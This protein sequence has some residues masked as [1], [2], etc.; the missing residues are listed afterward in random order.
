MVDDLVFPIEGYG[1]YIKK[2]RNNFI[3]YDED[4]ATS[5]LFGKRQLPTKSL[6]KDIQDITSAP[7]RVIRR[8]LAIIMEQLDQAH[9]LAK[10]PKRKEPEVFSE[11]IMAKAE[12]VLELD[13]LQYIV[14]TTHLLHAGDTELLKIEYVSALSSKLSKT[15][16]NLWPIGGSGKGKTHSM[17]TVI[18]LLPRDLYEVFT[19]ASPLSLF[20]Y[21]KRYGPSALDAILL[22]IDEVEAAKNALPMLRSL[23]GQTEITPRHLS[24]Y[25]AELLNLKIKG[26]RPIWFTSVKTFG[27]DQIKNRFINLNPDETENQDARV[28]E[29]QDRLFR[30]EESLDLEAFKIAQA[31]TSIIIKETDG[32]KVVI[33]FQIKWAYKERR[34][35]Y[36]VFLAFIRVI[37]KIH[38]K[39]RRRGA[40]GNIIAS[41]EDFEL[42]KNLW[43]ALEK[44]IRYRVTKSALS[45][46]DELSDNKSDAQTHAELTEKLPLGTRQIERLCEELLNEGLVNRAKRDVT[47]GRPAWE[48]WKATLPTIEDVDVVTG[49]MVLELIRNE[50]NGSSTLETDVENV[51]K[52]KNTLLR[53]TPYLGDG[54]CE[55]CE[56]KPMEWKAT[57]VDGENAV[58]GCA[59]CARAY[60]ESYR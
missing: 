54:L 26:Q 19:S 34:F 23:T 38:F 55:I 58:Y 13:P 42:A 25:D 12:K 49:D 16:I 27:S 52:S 11:D 15:K 50:F 7:L 31:M 29:V 9:K 59:G 10:V 30:E 53:L 48:Y 35:L 20:Y 33:P 22:F 41:I 8:T 57:D 47:R 6:A 39:H 51:Q 4:G 60:L 37:A 44:P 28:F 2:L 17:T 45:I 43:K 32:K 18:L 24:V 56:K 36:P 3:L 21:V 1:Y 40:N 5:L 46:L 14:D